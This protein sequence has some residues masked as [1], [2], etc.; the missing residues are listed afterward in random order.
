MTPSPADHAQLEAM[1]I[2]E[3]ERRVGDLRKELKDELD[4]LRERTVGN[5]ATMVVFSGDLDG[6]MAA[7]VIATGAASSSSRRP[8]P[9]RTGGR[10]T[11]TTWPASPDRGLPR[12]MSAMRSCLLTAAPPPCDQGVH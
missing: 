11:S 6:A 1:V 7:L 10:S 5:R 2:Q 8:R 4:A 3:V 12:L 9:T